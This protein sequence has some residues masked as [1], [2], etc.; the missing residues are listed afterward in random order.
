MSVVGDLFESWIKRQA[1]MKDSGTLLPGHGGILDRIDS[2][3]SSLPLAAM[4]LP[5]LV[6]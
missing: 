2:M 3:T 1:G 6:S 4:F 5:C